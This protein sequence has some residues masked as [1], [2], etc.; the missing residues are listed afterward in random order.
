MFDS[1]GY[2]LFVPHTVKG[3]LPP[4]EDP[5]FGPSGESIFSKYGKERWTS[6]MDHAIAEFLVQNNIGYRAVES[7]SFQKLIYVA[8]KGAYGTYMSR[9]KA[10]TL[11][12]SAFERMMQDLKVVIDDKDEVTSLS[13]TTDGGMLNNG[14]CY[15]TVTGHFI[16]KSWVLRSLLLGFISEASNQTGKSCSY[17]RAFC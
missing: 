13:L 9:T 4:R 17:V 10:A 12:R 2:N 5:T 8:T 11:V 14:Y 3:E 15:V 7:I 6:E 16:D 1:N